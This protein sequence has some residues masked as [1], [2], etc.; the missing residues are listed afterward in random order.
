MISQLLT[1]I[2]NEILARSE[3]ESCLIYPSARSEILAPAVFLEIANFSSADDPAT[4]ELALNISLEAR[5]IIDSSIENSEVIC[6]FLACN[7]ANLIHLNCFGC[8]VT[9]AQISGI[10]RDAFR[11]EF[12]M[13]TCW[14]IEWSHQIHIGNSVWLETGVTPHLLHINSEAVDE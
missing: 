4:E 3:I 9:P 11:P 2:R 5:V 6:Q 8:E 13:F 14:L 7:I 10:S 1:N 12:D